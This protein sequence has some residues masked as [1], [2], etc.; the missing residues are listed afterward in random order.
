MTEVSFTYCCS[1]MNTAWLDTEHK[2][3]GQ[4]SSI[5]VLYGTKW[6][7]VLL[8]PS[9]WQQ[10]LLLWIIDQQ[11]SLTTVDSATMANFWGTETSPETMGKD[12]VV[13]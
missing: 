7:Y 10:E 3:V 2:P 8:L 4:L 11:Q 1:D 13:F 9:Q 6:K 5:G 12:M